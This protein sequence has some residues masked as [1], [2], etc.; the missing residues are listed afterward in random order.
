MIFVTFDTVFVTLICFVPYD[1]CRL[2]VLCIL[3]AACDVV[4]YDVCRMPLL[5]FV[6]MPN[7]LYDFCKTTFQ[8]EERGAIS[9]LI[10]VLGKALEQPLGER[11]GEGSF[12]QTTL[13]EFSQ[14]LGPNEFFSADWIT[15]PVV[16]REKSRWV[17]ETFLR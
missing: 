3:Y 5:T 12:H 10:P 6:A 1:V 7:C 9:E 17:R 14:K 4:A 16:R 8:S 15:F 2:T 13:I 11:E